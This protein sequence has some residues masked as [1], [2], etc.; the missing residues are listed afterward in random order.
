MSHHNIFANNNNK[1]PSKKALT[2]GVYEFYIANPISLPL[3]L[4]FFFFFCSVTTRKKKCVPFLCT[5][6]LLYMMKS[7]VSTP[8]ESHIVYSVPSIKQRIEGK[9]RNVAVLDDKANRHIFS[10]GEAFPQVAQESTFATLFFNLIN[11]LTSCNPIPQPQYRSQLH[12]FR[13]PSFPYLLMNNILILKLL[14]TEPPSLL[15][16][17]KE[18]DHEKLCEALDLWA[19]VHACD[20]LHYFVGPQVSINNLLWGLMLYSK[21]KQRSLSV[22]TD[23]K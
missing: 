6:H 15:P 21:S 1:K 16:K 19:S 3:S 9:M 23:K 14:F 8:H 12:T 4:I 13:P 18:T 17:G 5:Q 11:T 22:H 7:L 2:Y 10:K 20:S